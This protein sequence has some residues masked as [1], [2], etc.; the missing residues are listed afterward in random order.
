MAA[1]RGARGRDS[2]CECEARSEED[3]MSRKEWGALVVVLGA[4]LAIQVV[5]HGG[6]DDDHA[7]GYPDRG[8]AAEAPRQ[9]AATSPESGTEA[10]MFRTV[11]LEVRG[12]T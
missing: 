4:V 1:G 2:C 8:P 12:M 5:G 6:S 11:A 3:D 7:E 9:P 10:G